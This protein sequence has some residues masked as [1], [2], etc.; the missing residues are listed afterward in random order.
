MTV[1]KQ[2]AGYFLCCYV[3]PALLSAGARWKLD[4]FL[5]SYPST[6]TYMYLYLHLLHFST[7]AQALLSQLLSPPVP[8]SLSAT[9]PGRDG[10]GGTAPPAS[11]GKVWRRENPGTTNTSSTTRSEPDVFSVSLFFIIIFVI[12]IIILLTSKQKSETYI[13]LFNFSCQPKSPRATSLYPQ[14]F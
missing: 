3:F 14:S 10:R 1:T 8:S 6:A 7:L 5:A 12:I 2:C 9:L 11:R 4:R 13:G